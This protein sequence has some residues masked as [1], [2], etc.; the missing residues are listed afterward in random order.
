MPRKRKL[1]AALQ[2]KFYHDWKVCKGLLCCHLRLVVLESAAGFGWN[3]SQG[4]RALSGA[5][6]VMLQSAPEPNGHM[7]K[8][9]PVT[10]LQQTG[11]GVVGYMQTSGARNLLSHI[12]CL[13][14]LSSYVRSAM[15]QVNDR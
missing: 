2:S 15:M 7:P 3:C 1:K 10:T 9:Q 14:A 4:Q 5:V 13:F 8:A 6:T 12:S 11:V